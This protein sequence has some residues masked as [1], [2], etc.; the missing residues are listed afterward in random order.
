MWI[1]KDEISFVDILPV[2][3]LFAELAQPYFL[4]GAR[5]QAMLTHLKALSKDLGG[6]LKIEGSRGIL[7]AE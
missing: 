7:T 4:D 3:G 6:V 1:D 2:A 5:A